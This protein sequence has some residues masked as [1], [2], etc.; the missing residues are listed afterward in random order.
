MYLSKVVVN[1]H[2]TYEQHQAI[3]KLFPGTPERKRDHLFRVEEQSQNSCKLLLQSSTQPASCDEA[4]VLITKEFNPQL[5]EGSFYKFKLVAYPTKCLSAGKK[6]VEI[7]E[8][9]AQ[10]E[11]LQRKL[12]G[13]NVQVTA[14][15]SFLV[16][17]KKTYN[18]R[19]VCFEG[20]IQVLNTQLIEKA[21]VMGIGRKKHAGA[22]LLSLA[23]MS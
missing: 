4:E 8:A 22:G 2:D 1:H 14:M 12:E 5:S 18:S 23:R 9:D 21:L 19:Y 11:W 15:D 17:S 6:V 13:A 16:S 10:V 20:I 7:K 3:W